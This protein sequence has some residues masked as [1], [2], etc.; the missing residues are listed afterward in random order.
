MNIGHVI[1]YRRR[2]NMDQD[3]ATLQYTPDE[4]ILQILKYLTN[5]VYA[6]MLVSRQF[7]RL[8]PL[9]IISHINGRMTDDGLD[10]CRNI[11]T[12]RS[13]AINIVSKITDAGLLG[14]GNLV[15]LCLGQC[16]ISD[17]GLRSMS[18]LRHLDISSNCTISDAGLR[19]L[20]LETLEL[21]NNHVISNDGLKHYTMLIGLGLRDNFRITKVGHLSTLRRL[22]LAKNT[23]IKD[24]ELL[25]L[26]LVH[27]DLSDNTVITDY[28]LTT[29][30]R[31]LNL[32]RN[33]RITDQ[34][35]AWCPGL[36][37][38]NLYRNQCITD[39]GIMQ[40]KLKFLDLSHNTQ[41]TRTCLDSQQLDSLIAIGY[42]Q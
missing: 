26:N 37:R 15:R 28:A 34:G 8:A 2:V 13:G 27:L 22:N 17:A 5:D 11:L 38:L 25:G 14:C 33:H 36:T 35:L 23:K 4:L 6:L 24:A 18:N 31:S 42:A 7:N 29:S 19:Q 30:L 41:I 16:T 12:L 9:T 39:E 10:K 20:Q 21:G 40:L 3:V 1:V 32:S